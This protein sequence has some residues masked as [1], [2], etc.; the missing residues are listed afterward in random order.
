[1]RER[2]T[3]SLGQIQAWSAVAI[4]C[5]EV[6]GKSWKSLWLETLL[7]TFFLFLSHKLRVGAQTSSVSFEV[8]ESLLLDPFYTMTH[9]CPDRVFL[10]GFISYVVTFIFVWSGS[11]WVAADSNSKK[12]SFW[13]LEFCEKS[14][15]LS[16]LPIVGS[17]PLNNWERKTH[18]ESSPGKLG[19][20]FCAGRLV[21][22]AC[23]SI[24]SR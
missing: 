8:L 15:L 6:C 24:L 12:S 10:P 1:M 9:Y 18:Q 3:L 14:Q 11:C 20:G 19:S 23:H 2:D 17:L 13:L 7:Q 21:L 16:S 5:H 22:T 4:I